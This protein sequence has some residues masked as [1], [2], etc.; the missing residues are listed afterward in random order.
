MA[1]PGSSSFSLGSSAG[2]ASLAEVVLALLL[3][4]VVIVG[5]GWL[6]R[7]V[8]HGVGGGSSARL[9]MVAALALGPRERVVVVALGETQL[10]LGVTGSSITF[11]HRLEEPLPERQPADSEFALRLRR[12]IGGGGIP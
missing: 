10:L 2:L 7:R 1:N 5:L 11:L 12:A 6:L 4:V 3:V 9:R 8:Q